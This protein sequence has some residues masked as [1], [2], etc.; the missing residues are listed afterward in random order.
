MIRSLLPA[1]VSALLFASP[2]ALPATRPGN[3]QV[4]GPGGG[5][6]MFHPTVSPHDPN[7]ILVSCDMT[8][9]Y[10]THDG[11]HSWR[12]FSLRGVV[13]FF[14]FHPFDPKVIY[15]GVNGLWRS[16]DGGETWRLIYPHP[17]NIRSIHMSDDHADERIVAQPDV[18]GSITAVAL[19]P[20]NPSVLY[21][22]GRHEQ[23]A[24]L[25]ESNDAGVTFTARAALP[26]GALRVWVD[27]SSP[28]GKRRFY[29][30]GERSITVVTPSATQTLAAPKGVAFT[31]ISG[32]FEQHAQPVFYAITETVAYRSVDGGKTWLKC[33]LP[34]GSNARF[35][36]VATSL[37]HP[38]TAYLSYG[39]LEQGGKV[40]LGVAKTADAGATWSFV[41]KESDVAARNVHDA[42]ITA[43]LGP[44]WASNPLALGVADQ[45]PSLCYATDFGRTMRTQ[46]GGANWIAQYS[47]QLPGAQW[48]TT[49]LDVTTSYGVHFDPFDRHRL[50]ITYTDIGLFRSEDG[51]KSWQSS[52]QGVPRKWWNTTYWVE[53][54]PK[55]KGRMW[56][57]NSY[58]H[59][60]P[61]PKMWRHN[62]V[63]HYQGGVCRSDDGGRTWV[64]SSDG[65]PET[66]PT[67]ILLDPSS[68]VD[69]R[70]L[71]VA[72]FGRG[73]YKSTDGG[74][75]WALKNK[76][77]PPQ[78][79]FAWRL[80]RAANGTLFLVV[81]RRSEHGQIGNAGDGAVYRSDDGAESW[82]RVVLPEGVNGP[83]GLTVDPRSKRLYL[84]AWAREV[85]DHG[86]GGGIYLSP[87]AGKTWR[88]VLDRDQHVYDVSIDPSHPN[89]LYAAGFE[90]SAWQSTDY[91]EH[92]KRIPGFNFKWGHR[93]IPDP[94]NDGQIYI[95][96]FGGSVWHGRSDGKP[97]AVDIA[98]PELMPGR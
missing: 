13:R 38:H 41:W 30:A 58:T 55:V 97:A 68:P 65:L 12:M 33:A 42:W 1:I 29:V 61:R 40:W 93:V 28:A 4:I 71:Y 24:V 7:T 56:S 8:G 78:E 90:S 21:V 19:D 6:A 44:D 45:D 88:H 5:G 23:Q 17:S 36:A 83:N 91:G 64:K 63:L 34:T 27:P 14:A 95:T 10:I 52:I 37:H 92:W 76:G 18:L 31:D 16:T 15:A 86:E 73:V 94:E 46:D 9:A 57:V 70:I 50:F 72:A 47:R 43:Q 69:A 81:A 11:G 84:S 79:P 74:K 59:D 89:H 82:Q 85:G 53:F 48:T 49:G 32:G 54:D 51:G 25:Y 26:E 77:L 60:L 80:A 39:S 87:D 62:S 75:T 22:A 67:H 3:F 2:V 66:G 96:T 35:A 20:S 98:T